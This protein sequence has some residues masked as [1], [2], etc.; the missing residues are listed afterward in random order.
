MSRTCSAYDATVKAIGF[1]EVRVRYRLLQRRA[2]EREIICRQLSKIQTLSYINEECAK[3]I[4][5]H[6]REAFVQNILDDL[7]HI[8]QGAIG[9]L[10]N[11]SRSAG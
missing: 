4:P 2:L 7:T 8:N 10:G 6:H 11:F 5:A 1:D 3:I 9:G